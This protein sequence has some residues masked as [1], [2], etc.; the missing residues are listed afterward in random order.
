MILSPFF[1]RSTL[2]ALEVMELKPP[3]ATSLAAARS[4]AVT[5]E[6]AVSA[7]TLLSLQA[8]A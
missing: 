2:Q 5:A 7:V 4:Q 3:T 6:R 8:R 1:R